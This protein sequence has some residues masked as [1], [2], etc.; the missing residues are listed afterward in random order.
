MNIAATGS[1]I[2]ALNFQMEYASKVNKMVVDQME[3]QGEMIVNLI[4]DAPA[5]VKADPTS[6]VGQII[7]VQV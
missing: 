7:D 6:A 3:T 2:S 5:G 1:A 4:P